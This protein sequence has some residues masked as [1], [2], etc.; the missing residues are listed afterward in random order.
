MPGTLRCLPPALPGLPNSD[1]PIQLLLGFFSLESIRPLD[2][3][4]SNNKLLLISQ[5]PAVPTTF[6]SQLRSA[7]AFQWL[8]A[9]PLAPA[10]AP[11]SLPLPT[12]PL[13]G[14]LTGS[15]FTTSRGWYFSPPPPPPSHLSP[16]MKGLP[17]SALG[18]TIKCQQ[19]S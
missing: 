8:R 9:K 14:N 17:A 2:L 3:S 11:F 6:P 18:P 16:F 1:T 10:S 13:A 5:E 15:T 19:S 7:P 12:S 4:T